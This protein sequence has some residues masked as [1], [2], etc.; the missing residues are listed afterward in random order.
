MVMGRVGVAATAEMVA[1]VGILGLGVRAGGAL[2]VVLGVGE[3][4]DVWVAVVEIVV[5]ILSGNLTCNDD[6]G[7]LGGWGWSWGWSWL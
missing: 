6:R 2:M 5:E 4:V 1:E 3:K 7:G